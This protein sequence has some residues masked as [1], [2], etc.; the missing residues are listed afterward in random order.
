MSTTTEALNI[1]IWSDVLCPFCYIG[2]RELEG[3][4]QHFEHRDKV[5]ITWHSFELDP[6]AARGGE[7]D[8]YSMLAERYGIS[9]AEASQRVQGV[10]ERAAG[11]GLTFRMDLARP[12][13]SFD[14]HRLLQFAKQ[15]GTG[16]AMKE[17]LLQ[18]YFSEGAHIAD[19]AVLQ[20]LAVEVG[21][22]AAAVAQVLAT[23]AFTAEVRA[24]EQ[25]ARRIGI[26]G[27]PFFVLDQR[28]AV[29]GAQA[30]ETFLGALRQAWDT[31]G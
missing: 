30:Q 1:D 21:L 16:G 13:N 19:H 7:Q 14:A 23:D 31:R 28:L 29:R 10:V 24:D 5:H 15:Q 8:T 9:L 3:A 25:D 2:K 4:L 17:R 20:Q 22:E 11:V 18:A 26:Q 6:H 27:V 12:T